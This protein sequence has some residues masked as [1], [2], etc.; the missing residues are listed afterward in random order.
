[1]QKLSIFENRTGIKLWRQI[2]PGGGTLRSESRADLTPKARSGNKLRTISAP[3]P[4]SANRT[5]KSSHLTQP[6][7][8]HCLEPSKIFWPNRTKTFHVKHF[9][10]IDAGRN[11]FWFVG[12]SEPLSPE[13]AA[14]R[15]AQPPPCRRDVIPNRIPF[16]TPPSHQDAPSRKR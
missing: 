4:L 3:P 14:K 1:V 11:K 9:G 7:R 13:K 12:F 2:R 5:K 10:T 6:M 8:R 15:E 16:R